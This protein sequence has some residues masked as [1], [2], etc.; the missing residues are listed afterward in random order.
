MYAKLIA[1]GNDW[2]VLVWDSAKDSVNGDETK[3]VRRYWACEHCVDTCVDPLEIGEIEHAAHWIRDSGQSNG[4]V[5][6]VCQECLHAG[7]E[8]GPGYRLTNRVAIGNRCVDMDVAVAY[9]NGAVREIVHAELAP[10][11]LQEFVDRYCE[12]HQERFNETFVVN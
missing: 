4:M 6:L 8:M 5:F 11:T 1:S 2:E 3:A 7:N 12:L 10:C 9:M